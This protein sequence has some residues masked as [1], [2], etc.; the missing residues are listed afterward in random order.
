MNNLPLLKIKRGLL[1]IKRALLP[2][3][4]RL[5]QNSRGLLIGWGGAGG[6]V[7]YECEK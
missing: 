1:R 6:A 5:L 2:E 7:P 4:G 3:K